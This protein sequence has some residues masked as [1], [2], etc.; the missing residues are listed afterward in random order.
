MITFILILVPGKSNYPTK[1]SSTTSSVTLRLSPLNTGSY[2]IIWNPPTNN[3]S[4]TGITG[5]TTTIND[6]ISNTAY[7]FTLTAENSAG[8]GQPSNSVTFYTGKQT[9]IQIN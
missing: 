7:I 4:R 1:I 9:S 6:L 2:A 3:G 5:T 8:S